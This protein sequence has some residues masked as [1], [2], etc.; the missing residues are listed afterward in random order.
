[1]A[2]LVPCPALDCCDPDPFGYSITS[3]RTYQNN[4]GSFIFDCPPG[5]ICNPNAYPVTILVSRGDIPW[6]PPPYNPFDPAPAVL[7][8]PGCQSEIVVEV[9]VGS[10]QAGYDSIVNG[11]LAQATAQEAACREAR[12]RQQAAK[13]VF[14]NVS[15]T[16]SCPS[17]QVLTNVSAVLPKGI[18]ISGNSLVLA[19]S[20]FASKKSQSDAD[21]Q[22][23]TYLTQYFN[24]ALADGSLTCSIPAGCVAPAVPDSPCDLGVADNTVLATTSI[25]DL[26][27]LN[28]TSSFGTFDVM[29]F[30]LEYVSGCYTY[31]VLC[32][33]VTPAIEYTTLGHVFTYSNGFSSVNLTQ[34]GGDRSDHG[35]GCVPQPADCS[36]VSGVNSFAFSHTGGVVALKFDGHGGYGGVTRHNGSPN[37][38]W[39]LRRTKKLAVTMPT[40]VRIKNFAFVQDALVACTGAFAGGVANLWDGTF[41][42][43]SQDFFNY[44]FLPTFPVQGLQL[45]GKRLTNST[46][47]YHDVGAQPTPTGCAWILAV[48]FGTGAAWVG[49]GGGGL[50]PIGTYVFRTDVNGWGL[51]NQKTDALAAT[52]VALPVNTLTGII[53][54]ASANGAFP[55]IDGV[56]IP[57]NGRVLVTM[58]TDQRKNGLYTLTQVG[59]GATPW[60]LTRTADADTSAEVT[61]GIF[62]KVTGGVLNVGCFFKQ[63]TLD[64]ITLGTTPLVWLKV[65]STLVIESF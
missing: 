39:R 27:I 7:R 51:C 28:A 9:P 44:T 3:G 22:A 31:D 4:E 56:A 38:T 57:L 48:D 59:S 49:I 6:Q 36:Y 63:T 8:F 25:P 42:V 61:Q 37:P 58:E 24:G 2:N 17:G 23:T 64:P 21:T 32:G 54:T 33:G 47:V 14:Y 20:R 15:V 62:V 46:K 40:R 12:Y 34:S 26:T 55:T 18:T 29:Q 41:D 50:S 19:A 10:S 13:K 5:F 65:P 1:M 43:V 45:N 60:K 30:S 16:A 52:P 11:I 53:L 35:G